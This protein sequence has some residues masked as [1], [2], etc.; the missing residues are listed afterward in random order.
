MEAVGRLAGGVAHDFNNVLSVILSYTDLLLGDPS[1]AEEIR[2]DITEMKTAGERA[3]EWTKQLLLFSRQ[4][5]LDPKVLDLGQVVANMDKML[6]R[7]LG[8]DIELVSCGQAPLSK[9]WIDGGSVAQIIMN[10]AVNARDAMPTG[11]RLTIRTRNAEIDEKAA[12]EVGAQPGAYVVLSVADTG[13]G[14]DRAHLD[15]IF[16][17]FFTTK[18]AGK[19]TGLGLS[20][21]F[22]IVRQCGGAVRVETEIDRGTTFEVYLPAAEGVVAESAPP[23][24]ASRAAG[25]E[26][27]LVVEDDAQ[28]RQVVCGILR[29]NGY[30]V[31]EARG[32][33]DALT[34]ADRHAGAI[35][36]LLSDV[37]MP[38]MSGPEL[39]KRIAARRPDTKVLCMSGYTDDSIARHGLSQS[40]VAYVRKPITPDT[41]AVRVREILDR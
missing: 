11:G 21:V 25:F 38:Q 8:E 31:L 12:P 23:P 40:Q 1:L 5:A 9:V 32:A 28:V 33:T 35:H 30:A 24:S 4:Q 16:E 14:I 3:A 27:I 20:T 26:T 37:V 6:Q 22:A 10:L 18:G 34:L 17:P 29:R 39:A 15:R 7:I 2:A 19:G 36:L 13:T 41:L